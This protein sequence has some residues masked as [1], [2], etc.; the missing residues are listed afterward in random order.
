MIHAE[1]CN[2]GIFWWWAEDSLTHVGP[3][4]SEWAVLRLF[5][6]LRVEKMALVSMTSYFLCGVFFFRG[7]SQSEINL[8]ILP[9]FSSWFSIPKLPRKR[10]RRKQT[11]KYYAYDLS[12]V[13]KIIMACHGSVYPFPFKKIKCS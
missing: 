7:C 6:H 1:D 3:P 12:H 10:E 4:I 5:I 13:R 2:K 9:V 8:H 11:A